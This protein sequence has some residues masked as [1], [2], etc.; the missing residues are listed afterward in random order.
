MLDTVVLA[1]PQVTNALFMDNL[2]E[3]YQAF[4]CCH[5]LWVRPCLPASEPIPAIQREEKIRAGASPLLSWCGRGDA[6]PIRR[7]QKR[8]GLFH[9]VGRVLSFFSSR[10]NWDSPNPSPASECAPPPLGLGQG[11]HSLAREGWERANS[12]DGTYTVVLF[13]RT[14][15]L[16]SSNTICTSLAFVFLHSRPT[17]LKVQHTI[18]ARALSGEVGNRS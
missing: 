4:F 6:T 12:D 13:I 18:R 10:R 11:A 3:E 14:L 2:T 5:M 8:V 1:F 9:R 15:W 17:S 7:Q 16:F